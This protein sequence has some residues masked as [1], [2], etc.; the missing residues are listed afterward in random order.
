MSNLWDYLSLAKTPRT[1][2]R[3]R[4]SVVNVTQLFTVDKRDL[5]KHIGTL[6]EAR[7]R[8]I[9]DGIKLVLEPREMRDQKGGLRRPL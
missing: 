3:P 1:Q 7:V 8:Q 6:P 4:P 5:L 9:L 2:R